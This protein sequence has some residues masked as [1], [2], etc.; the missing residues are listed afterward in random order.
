MRGGSGGGGQTGAADERTAELGECTLEQA[1]NR[2][3]TVERK[4]FTPLEKAFQP[5]EE[6]MLLTFF[7]IKE[8]FVFVIV[9]GIKG[10]FAN[11]IFDRRPN[12]RQHLIDPVAF[13]VG[14]ACIRVKTQVSGQ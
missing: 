7:A 9:T 6:H 3:K 11:G 8:Q 14:H 1:V 4:I 2:S 10:Q 5:K 13:A 12:C